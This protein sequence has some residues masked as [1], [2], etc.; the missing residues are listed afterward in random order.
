MKHIPRLAEE[1]IEGM[2]SLYGNILISDQEQFSP[3]KLH[4]VMVSTV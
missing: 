3:F 2:S 1:A 4:P